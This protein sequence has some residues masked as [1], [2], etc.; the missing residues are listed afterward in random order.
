MFQIVINFGKICTFREIYEDKAP[1]LKFLS[2]L[3]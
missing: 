2:S 3:K 1:I